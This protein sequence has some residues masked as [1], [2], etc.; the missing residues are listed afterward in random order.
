MNISAETI[1]CCKQYIQS[2]PLY[3]PG[4][5][6]SSVAREYG[7]PESSILKLASNENPL[8]MRARLAIAALATSPTSCYPDPEATELKLRLQERFGVPP[9]WITVGNGSSEILE[10]AA[11]AFAGRGDSVVNVPICFRVLLPCGCQCGGDTDRGQFAQ[12][13]S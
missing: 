9:A 1:P 12:F 13:C 6:A 10:M 2:L 8:G 4:R 11:K 7:F 3:V 5:A